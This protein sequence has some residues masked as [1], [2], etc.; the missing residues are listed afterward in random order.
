MGAAAYGRTAD[1]IPDSGVG[2]GQC[3][4]ASTMEPATASDSLHHKLAAAL[5][6]GA[7]AQRKSRILLARHRE[8]DAAVRDTLAVIGE[9]QRAAA[10]RN[11]HP[12]R[13]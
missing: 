11:P 7:E 2:R 12:P 8:V 5:E 10:Q 4:N 6:R 1:P 13:C 9:R 3:V